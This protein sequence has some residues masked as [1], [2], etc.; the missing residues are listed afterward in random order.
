MKK[1][2]QAGAILVLSLMFLLLG[3]LY[4]LDIAVGNEAFLNGLYEKYDSAAA[5]GITVE[6]TEAAS[7]AFIDYLYGRVGSP[8]TMVVYEGEVRPFLN[9][10]EVSHMVDCRGLFKLKTGA[11]VI[12][13]PLWLLGTGLLVWKKQRGM[14]WKAALGKNLLGQFL[15]CGLWVCAVGAVLLGGF[16]RAFILFHKLFFSNDLWLLDPK[17]DLMIRMLPEGYFMDIAIRIGTVACVF[18]GLLLLVGAGL[19]CWGRKKEA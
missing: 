6:E 17:T 12:L 3:A 15:G 18:V 1:L 4:A 19:S 7:R 2:L 14:G 10:K 13:T 9:E 5:V 8:N 16:N 11:Q